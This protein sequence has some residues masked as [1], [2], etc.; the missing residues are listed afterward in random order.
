MVLTTINR[1]VLLF[2][3]FILVTCC[4]KASAESVE[5]L[6]NLTLEELLKVKVST[7]SRKE[8]SLDESPA[9]I[10]IITQ[11]DLQRRG[12]KDLSHILEDIG[13]IQ[14]TRIFGDNYFSTMWRG[15]RHT[16]GSSHL[17]LV[18]GIKFNHLYSNDAE[19]LAALPMSNIKQI[20]IVHGPASVAYGPDAVVGIINIITNKYT[21]QSNGFIQYGENG[22]RIIDFSYTVD[23][24]NWYLN[25]TGRYDEGQVDFSNA[26]NYRWT[27]PSLL[28]NKAVWGEFSEIYGEARSSHY[29]KSLS[30][31]LTDETSEFVVDYHEIATGYGLSLIHI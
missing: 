11:D 2:L 17:L 13:G 26:A 6:F 9:F 31:S 7:V 27:N 19:I 23:W 1:T 15:V 3:S 16:I 28:Q 12:Y 30:F 21:G 8:E 24:A 22:T 25:V 29:N 4:Q 14:V 10:E 5:H 18:D 20:E